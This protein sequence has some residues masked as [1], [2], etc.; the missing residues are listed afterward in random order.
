MRFMRV[1][2][3]RTIFWA[4][5]ALL[6]VVALAAACGDDSEADVD[7]DPD[8]RGTI[9]AV[10]PGMSDV[11]GY[12]RIEGNIEPDTEYDAAVVRIEEDTDIF[13]TENGQQVVAGFDD[14]EAGQQVEAWFTG[15]VAESYPVQAKA[16]RIVILENAD[17]GEP[18]LTGEVVSVEGSRVYLRDDNPGAQYPEASVT[19]PGDGVVFFREGE[20]L[21]PASIGDLAVG[22]AVE[23]WFG[24]I[25]QPSEPPMV[26]AIR[27]V[28]FAAPD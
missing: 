13:R 4:T 23:A 25:I 14:L 8:I 11:I 12:A 16:S 17:L 5:T 9:T 18:H 24:P 1:D 21:T 22:Q 2:T 27:I 10:S 6:A 19:V 28:I 7:D 3:L 26:T 20:D 15:A